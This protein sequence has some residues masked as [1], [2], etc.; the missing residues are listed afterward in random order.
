MKRILSLSALLLLAGS[1]QAQISPELRAKFIKVIATNASSAGRVAI[2]DPVLVKA[3][4]A[5][6]VTADDTAKVAYATTEAEVKALAGPGRLVVCPELELL[7]K[8]AS[9]AIVE[10]GGR[11]TVYLHAGNLNAS[12]VKVSAAILSIGKR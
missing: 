6:G 9:I 12:G 8:G 10:E 2:K 4:E 5:L 7:P 3:L 1:L 11:P